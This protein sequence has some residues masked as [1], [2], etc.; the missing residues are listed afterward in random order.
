MPAEKTDAALE[1]VCK[2]VFSRECTLK[3][4]GNLPEYGLTTG[5][6]TRVPHSILHTLLNTP[7]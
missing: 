1:K 2:G 4:P 7:L 6:D 3:V 5:F